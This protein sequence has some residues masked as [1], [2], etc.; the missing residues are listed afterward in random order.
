[1]RFLKQHRFDAT[2]VY[3]PRRS[4][5]EKWFREGWCVG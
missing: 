4:D 3:N 1:V 5:R 2:K